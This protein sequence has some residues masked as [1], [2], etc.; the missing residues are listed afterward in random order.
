MTR[1]LLPVLLFVSAI[2]CLAA[3]DQPL[4]LQ[5]PTVSKTHIVFSYAGDLWSVPRDGGEAARLTVG[6]GIETDPIFSPDGSLIAFQG[7]YEGNQDVYVIPAAGGTPKRLTYHPGADEPVGWTPD[8]KQ[9]LFRSNR[10]A[11][12]RFTELFTISVD[13]GFPTAVDLPMASDG[14]F[15]EDSSKLAYMP[16]SPAFESWKRYRGGRTTSIWLANLADAKVEKIP[17]ENSNDFNPIWLGGNVY[18]LSDRAGPVS[19]FSYDTTTK[20]IATWCTTTATTSSRPARGLVPSCTNSSV[21]FIC[22]ICNRASRRRS[23]SLSRATFRHC[24][25][26]LKNWPRE[27]RTRASRPVVRAPFLRHGA[28]SSPCRPRRVMC[29]I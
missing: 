22:S 26:P 17:R 27:S 1:I 4:L 5:K 14:S 7:E 13:G 12:S 29:A 23:R 9:I 10:N 25:L 21:P 2:V 16:I 8:G 15:S 11:Y 6:Q 24:G 18:F 3:A 19:L 28:K 20:K